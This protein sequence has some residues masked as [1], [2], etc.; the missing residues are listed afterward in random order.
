MSWD[1]TSD[2]PIRLPSGR[3]LTTLRDAGNFIAAYPRRST[4]GRNGKLQ[5]RFELLRPRWVHFARIG[6]MQA[7]MPRS[8]PDYDPK[9]KTKWRKAAKGS[10]IET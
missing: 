5:W 1:A 3:V 8:K 9:H 4:T 10:A 6:L 7:M 2:E